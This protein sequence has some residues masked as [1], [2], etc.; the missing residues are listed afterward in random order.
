M[1]EK[2][3]L[4]FHTTDFCMCHMHHLLRPLH[5][6]H[7][8]FHSTIYFALT[9]T[10]PF[11]VRPLNALLPSICCEA[12]LLWLYC[13]GYRHAHSPTTSTFSHVLHICF[14][15]LPPP[16]MSFPCMP[17]ITLYS[18]LSSRSEPHHLPVSVCDAWFHSMY[19]YH[20][21]GL[22]S[23][24]LYVHA[25]LPLSCVTPNFRSKLLCCRAPTT[26]APTSFMLIGS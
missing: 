23:L 17:H 20:R 22:F 13:H 2:E 15:F 12:L 7:L 1:G 24:L 6:P 16:C 8:R 9:I 14:V 18:L 4:L 11:Y 3:K 26:E 19:C 5:S 21:Q 25:A 10:Q